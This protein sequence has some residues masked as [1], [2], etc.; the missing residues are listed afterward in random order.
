M[1][2][3][4]IAVNVFKKSNFRLSSARNNNFPVGSEA[5][6]KINETFR[7]RLQQHK[8]RTFRK[9]INHAWQSS[10]YDTKEVV[11]KIHNLKHIT[12]SQIKSHFL[13]SS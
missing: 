7:F 10:L 2:Y 4:I 5:E 1:I 12:W 3:G 8:E 9:I 6:A 13:S 11:L